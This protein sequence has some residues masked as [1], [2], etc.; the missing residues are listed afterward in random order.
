MY[1]LLLLGDWLCVYATA[2]LT[3]SDSTANVFD[4]PSNALERVLM[5]IPYMAELPIM[6]YNKINYTH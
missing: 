3:S 5:T 2:F 4:K 6:A 1:Q